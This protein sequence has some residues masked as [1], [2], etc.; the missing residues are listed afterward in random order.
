MKR[1][2]FFCCF[3]FFVFFFMVC[4]C[5]CDLDVIVRSFFV[6]F[7]HI[8]N[9]VFCQ[10]QYIDSGYLVSTT[11]HTTFLIETLHVWSC[12]CAFDIIFVFIFVTFFYLWTLSF[13]D[14]RYIDSGYLVIATPHT[15]LY[16]S[17][18]NFAHVFSGV[19]K[20]ACALDI[21]FKF[22][23]VTFSTLTLSFSYLRF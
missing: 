1:C 10:P 17:F 9:L 16:R 5:A 21:I 13:S 4:G 8:V 19:C 23:F 14:H 12:A 3:F 7:F 22:I 18:W 6:T 11:P 15:I 2:M 20:S